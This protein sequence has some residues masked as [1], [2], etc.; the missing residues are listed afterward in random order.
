MTGCT[1]FMTSS[2]GILTID[3]SAIQS[4]W[5][6]INSRLDPRK[7]S[8]SAVIK[9]NA[10]G[11]GADHVGPAL[12]QVGCREF[13]LATL[14]E[15]LASRRHLPSD[16]ILYVLG[17]ARAGA[18]ELF[19]QHRLIPVLSSLKDVHRWQKVCELGGIKGACAIKVNTGMTRLGLEVDEFLQLCQTSLSFAPMEPVLI[20]SH[21]SCADELNHPA[22]KQQLNEF[23]RI[24][25]VG[26]S[27]LPDVRFSLANSSGIFLGHQWHFDLVRPGAALYG[28]NPQTSQLSPVKPVVS[29]DLPVL[30][31]RK[32][33][34]PGKVGYGAG[35][36]MGASSILAVVAG[37]YADG[38]HRTIGNGGVG[39]LAGC[40]VPVVGRISMDT[41]VFDISAVN[42]HTLDDDTLSI[43]VLNK[44]LTLDVVM[45]RTGAL[46]YE[47]LTSLGPRYQ[48]RYLGDGDSS[49]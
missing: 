22:N 18:E 24:V 2:T 43:Q 8:A 45:S 3:L 36:I 39:M 38:L 10:Y 37:G 32:M 42:E 21:L 23:L 31:V 40:A 6:T 13:F 12:Y 48:R 11:L 34:Q 1:A 35:V 49:L 4:N 28:I 46:G 5:L 17:G 20:M 44:Q 7:T 47:I 16:A 9:A 27:I 33:R 25:E 14:E 29:L 30:Q 41:T 19:L 15:A 26:K